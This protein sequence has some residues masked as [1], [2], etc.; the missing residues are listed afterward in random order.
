M[1]FSGRCK[2]RYE[3]EQIHSPMYFRIL[4][5]AFLVMKTGEPKYISKKDPED[6]FLSLG[7]AVDESRMFVLSSLA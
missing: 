5:M 3:K 6:A 7:C 2:L 4:T 1:L